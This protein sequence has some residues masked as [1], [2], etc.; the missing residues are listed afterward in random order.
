VSVPV[1]EVTCQENPKTSTE[2][3]VIPDRY[4]LSVSQE[5]VHE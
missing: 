1:L 4:S 5:E 2:G 3:F